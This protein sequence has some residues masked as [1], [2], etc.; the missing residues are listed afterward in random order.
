M[1]GI[2]HN[3]CPIC[4][5][6]FDIVAISAHMRRIAR[7][8]NCGHAFVQNPP[9]AR[10]LWAW[11]QGESYFADNYNRQGIFSLEDDAEWEGWLAGRFDELEWY[12][13]E[14]G[15]RSGP[16]RRV[17][18]VGCLEGRL[19]D[20]LGRRGHTVAGCDINET[21]TRR[22]SAAFGR[23]IRAGTVDRCAPPIGAFDV[24][25]VYFV[26]QYEPCPQAVFASWMRLLAPGGRIFC[27][28]PVGDS[29]R[30]DPM[31]LHFFSRASLALL[32][33]THL[34]DYRL[35]ITAE[36]RPGRKEHKAVLVG[37]RQA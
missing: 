24:V 19:L 36:D 17:F 14:A 12:I 29:G 5:G 8:R 3:A 6:V 25:L 15:F 26:L 4:G 10:E 16:P 22:G 33:Q 37:S 11:F 9:S 21:M 27:I 23:D 32:A 13:P 31:C 2:I 28:F 30:A 7:C 18:E 20:A 1:T 34:Y 35:T